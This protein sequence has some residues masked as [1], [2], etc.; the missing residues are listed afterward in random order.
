MKKILILTSL[1]LT[2]TIMQAQT[3]RKQPKPGPA[4][5]V[6]IGKPQRFTLSNGLKVMVV[7]NSKLP[8]VSFN[9]KIDN[10][11]FAEGNKKGI[12]N[13]TG[14]MMGKGTKTISKDVFNEEIDFLGANINFSADGAYASGLSKYAGRIME[15]M[16]QG[17]LDPNFTQEELDKEKAKMI[18]GLKSN[19]K[20]VAAVAG[21]VEDYLTFGKNHPRGEYMT[22][23]TIN[24]V[25]LNDLVQHY[26]TYFVPE[27]AY[28][29]I[30]GDVKFADVKAKVETA[31]E[32]WTKATAPQLSYSEPRNVQ[33]T[34][35]NFV[36]MPNAVQSEIS[37][38]N[39]VNLK[40]TDKD[41]FAAIVANQVV[42]GD[43]NSYLNM[44]LRE[45][46]GWTYGAGSSI[47]G[48]KYVTKFKSS[49]QVRNAV[50][51]SAVVEFMNELK[52]I[53]KEK[54]TDE[55][56]KNVKAGFIG[57]FVMQ[58]QK[59]E[60]VARYALN[61][62][63]QK[64][65]AD[66]Y[67]NYIKSIN[68]VTA[69][70]VL[71]VANKYFLVDNTRIIITGKGSEVISGLEKLK[72]PIFYFDKFGLPAKKTEEKKAAVGTTVKSVI[73]KYIAA[74]G[75][76]QAVKAVKT[77]ATK[78][79]ATVQG[80]P[81]EMTIKNS[82]DGKSLVEMTMM[83]NSMMKQVVGEKSGYAIQQGQRKEYDAAKLAEEKIEALPFPELA[84]ATKTDVTL[85]PIQTVDGKETYGIKDGKKTYFFDLASGLKTS[86]TAEM[87]A[88]GQK[89]SQTV[90]FSDY[91]E[92]KGIMF[93]YKMVLNVGMEI[94]LITSDVKIN[95]GVTE[96]DFK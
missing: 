70:D 96:E 29:V 60:T 43:F 51:D 10:A 79:T 93:P 44:N 82:S 77:T 23:Q 95:E 91:K 33:Y 81:M 5:T 37:V 62:E 40:M 7:E 54:V 22:E 14:T 76:E 26:N 46:H 9:L 59:P 24:N 13:L 11:P 66:F 38:V 71:R 69:D 27:N 85:L 90:T 6:N 30:I 32:S 34:Q 86:T 41:Y 15:L 35:I 50:T 42:G 55:N 74:I 83:G 19:E 73:D 75:G 2:I 36:D 25:T 56:L 47:S 20:S 18:E 52:R 92:V 48:N 63:T 39:T 68:A 57:K 65:P 4:P 12:D 87:E 49:S 16:A 72:I 84:L 67:E 61:T 8:R 31:F 45:K 3:E 80:M 64:L 94:E 21:R 88:N 58:I 28:L 53:R 78:A 1:F 17:S 89:M